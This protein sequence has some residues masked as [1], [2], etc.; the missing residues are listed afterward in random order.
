MLIFVKQVR[1]LY[2]VNKK[3]QKNKILLVN[4]WLY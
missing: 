2:I 1:E 3:N 4:I